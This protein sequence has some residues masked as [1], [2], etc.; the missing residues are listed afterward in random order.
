MKL[1]PYLKKGDKVAITCPAKKLSELPIDAI[2]LL[3]SWGL[4]VVLGKTVHG[5]HHQF[6]GTD[7]ERAADLQQFLDEGWF[8]ISARSLIKITA[9]ISRLPDLENKDFLPFLQFLNG[10]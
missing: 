8:E 4:E 5:A 6:S 7:T 10:I 1:P 2:N 9:K 3:E